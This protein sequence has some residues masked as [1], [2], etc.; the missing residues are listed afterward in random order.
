MLCFFSLIYT[1]K[2][3]MA[4]KKRTYIDSVK[5]QELVNEMNESEILEFLGKRIIIPVDDDTYEYLINLQ[6]NGNLT[7]KK[8]DK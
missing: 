5:I 4:N 3:F 7:I 1:E 2:V 6:R 8:L